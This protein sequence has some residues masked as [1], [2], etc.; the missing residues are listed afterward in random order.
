MGYCSGTFECRD[1]LSSYYV[2]L[3]RL[4]ASADVV[5]NLLFARTHHGVST[6]TVQ[7]SRCSSTQ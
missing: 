7:I 1:I 3:I 5:A 2:V 6:G 4:A